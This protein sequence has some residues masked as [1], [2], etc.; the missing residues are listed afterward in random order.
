MLQ[1]RDDD[2]EQI[3]GL[4]GNHVARDNLGRGND[5][6]LERRGAIIGVAIDFHA[7]LDL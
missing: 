1:V 4:P 2:F 6:L 5:R 7:D 3:V